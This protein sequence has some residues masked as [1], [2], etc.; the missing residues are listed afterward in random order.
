MRS[1]ATGVVDALVARFAGSK[2]LEVSRA[3]NMSQV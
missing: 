3:L 1:M 2:W